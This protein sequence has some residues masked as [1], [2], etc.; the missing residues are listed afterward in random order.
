RELGIELDDDRLNEVFERF[1]RLADKKKEIFDED[2]LTLLAE[3]RAAA[4]ERIKLVSL[5]VASGTQDTPV[6]AVE[7]EIDGKI[8]KATSEGDGPV[9]ATFRAINSLVEPHGKLLLYSVNAITSGT[10]AQ[11]EVTVRLQDGDRI[12]GGQGADTDIIVA[13]AKALIA[14]LNKL[15]DAHAKET[16]PQYSGI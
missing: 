7:L 10:D 2:L 13:S 5:H 1:K 12:V 16:H 6:A 4:R 14:A 11:G 15:P 8:Y 3:D 9:D